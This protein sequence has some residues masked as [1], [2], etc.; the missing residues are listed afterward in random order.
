MRIVARSRN[1]FAMRGGSDQPKSVW[2]LTGT[3]LEQQV[4][5]YK[6]PTFWGRFLAIDQAKSGIYPLLSSVV[7]ASLEA[8]LK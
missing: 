2:P 4:V 5:V 6:S 8:R 1:S 7:T 3:A